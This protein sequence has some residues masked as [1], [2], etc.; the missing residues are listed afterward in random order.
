MKKILALLGISVLICCLSFAE[1]QNEGQTNPTDELKRH[2]GT[3][4]KVDAKEKTITLRLDPSTSEQNKTG[5]QEVSSSTQTQTA[6]AAGELKVL[7]FTDKTTIA[8]IE[9]E[10]APMTTKITDL[11]SDDRIIVY[12]DSEGL[13]HK[14]EM[15]VDED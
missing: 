10:E 11:D 9:T 7:R 5:T 3:I 12:V 13:I 6:T 2:S 15:T 4:Q 8:A 14:I 1:N